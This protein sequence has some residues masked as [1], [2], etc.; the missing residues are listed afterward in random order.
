MEAGRPGFQTLILALESLSLSHK[1]FMVVGLIPLPPAWLCGLGAYLV[2]GMQDIENMPM[3]AWALSG[4]S[5]HMCAIS[6]DCS[7]ILDVLFC[8]WSQMASS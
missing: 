5:L 4:A 7:V 8:N 1:V 2:Q 6:L 3:A